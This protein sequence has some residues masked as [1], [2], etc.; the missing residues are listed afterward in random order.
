MSST[1]RFLD[2]QMAVGSGR[3]D[4]ISYKSTFEAQSNDEYKLR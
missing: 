2:T 1:P 3:K 4:R